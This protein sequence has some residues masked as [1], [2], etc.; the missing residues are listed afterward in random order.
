MSK[1]MPQEFAKIGSVQHTQNELLGTLKA[2]QERL[3]RLEGTQPQAPAPKASK[4]KWTDAVLND[5]DHEQERSR[6]QQ[7]IDE[8]IVMLKY[9]R[10]DK[11]LAK[12]PQDARI[13]MVGASRCKLVTTDFETGEQKKGLTDDE[14][15]TLKVLAKWGA[16]VVIHR[17]EIVEAP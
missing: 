14:I 17:Q 16:P 7:Q 2:M 4:K 8:T 10:L 5:R 3:E 12:I 13:S 1:P 15:S 11:I 6:V 9:R